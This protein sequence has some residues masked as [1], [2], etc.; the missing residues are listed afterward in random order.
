MDF[1]A[2]PAWRE[3]LHIPFAAAGDLGRFLCDHIS[4]G[5]VGIRPTVSSCNNNYEVGTR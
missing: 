5:L 3:D 1:G 2:L 4:G